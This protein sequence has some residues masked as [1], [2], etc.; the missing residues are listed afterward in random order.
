MPMGIAR[1]HLP[2]A[3]PMGIAQLQ[4]PWAMPMGTAHGKCPWAMP[5]GSAHGKVP[6]GNCPRALPV[7]RA[8][9]KGPWALPTGVAHGGGGTAAALF[10][11]CASSASRLFADRIAVH[12]ICV[13]RCG[14]RRRSDNTTTSAGAPVQPVRA[15]RNG[16]KNKQAETVDGRNNRTL[17]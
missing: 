16:W 15:I 3:M 17:H 8:H 7:G 4:C 5:M 1:G 2:W 9:G 11:N 12:G 14:W 6:M 13:R 10:E